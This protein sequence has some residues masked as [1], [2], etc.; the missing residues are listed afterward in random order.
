MDKHRL[1]ITY[2]HIITHNYIDKHTSSLI[3]TDAEV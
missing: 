3:Y 1:S 2:I